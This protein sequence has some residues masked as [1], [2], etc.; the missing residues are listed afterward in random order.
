MA[1][2]T[3]IGLRL[4]SIPELRSGDVEL[5]ERL[6]HRIEYGR[7][8][9]L[10]YSRQ[11]DA[12]AAAI[13]T[14]LGK[15]DVSVSR[16]ISMLRPGQPWEEALHREVAGTDCFIVLVSP[17]SAAAGSFVRREVEWALN[18]HDSGGLVTT[19]LPI[20]LPSGGWE[21]FPELHRFQWWDYPARA[22]RREVFDRLAT[23]IAEETARARGLRSPR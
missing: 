12:A 3:N 10:S 11:D 2:T 7:N 14:E 20:V 15:S 18:E 16:D 21:A 8:V 4:L 9:F 23:G 13:E 22:A 5:L 1:E 19:I 17:S 6:Q